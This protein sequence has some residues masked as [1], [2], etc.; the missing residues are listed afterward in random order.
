MKP[1]SSTLLC[2]RPQQASQVLGCI[3]TAPM[4]LL[5]KQHHMDTHGEQVAG[6]AW[7]Q[8]PGGRPHNSWAIQTNGAALKHAWGGLP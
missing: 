1:A 8:F 5:A 7:R 2:R 6:A 4:S 3:V